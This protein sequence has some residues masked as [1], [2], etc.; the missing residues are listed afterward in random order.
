MG[1]DLD[2][3]NTDFGRFFVS[4]IRANGHDRVSHRPPSALSPSLQMPHVLFLSCAPFSSCT[5]SAAILWSSCGEAT[6]WGS[7][8]VCGP[9]MRLGLLRSQSSPPM[10]VMNHDLGRVTVMPPL[11]SLMGPELIAIGGKSARA[12]PWQPDPLALRHFHQSDPCG[13]S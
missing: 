7:A 1:V 8:R 3:L 9:L 4:W 10:A 5:L 2:E 11:H 6:M 12:A 13:R